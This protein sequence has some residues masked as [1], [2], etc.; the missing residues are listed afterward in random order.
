MSDSIPLPLDLAELDAEVAGGSRLRR[1]ILPS[2][3]RLIT[4]HVPGVA[5]AAIGCFVP[6]GSR[7]ESEGERGSSHFLEH[8]LFKG[9]AHRTAFEIA[10]SF[11]RVGGDFNASTSREETVYHAR[12][13]DHDLPLAIDVLADMMTSSVLDPADFDLE[14]GVILEEIAM[15]EDDPVDTLWERFYADYFGDHPL[16]LPIAG[17][18]ASIESV[19]RDDTNDFYRRTYRPER[20]VVAIAG[21]VDHDAARDQLDAGLRRG[22]W[23]LDRT[24][25]PV[26]RRRT[27]PAAF[28]RTVPLRAIERDLEQT[29][30]LIAGPGITSADPRRTA[31]GVLHHVLGGGMSSRLFQE[32][33][34]RRGLV[35]SVFSFAAFHADAGLSGVSLS[36]LP[37]KAAAA[38]DVVTTE[39]DRLA[40]D[41]ITDDELAD[42]RTAAIGAG[43][44]ALE[45][46]PARM[47]RLGRSELTLGEFT[48]LDALTSKMESVTASQVAE[49]ARDMTSSS[50]TAAT[51][52][53]LRDNARAQLE[54]MTR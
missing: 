38:I 29:N 54:R 50:L 26:A 39:V 11:E 24:S 13:R 35:Y 9:T 20:L 8:L 32:V 27:A 40:A 4:E 44:L 30:L 53:P 3:V 37:D 33:R 14:R 21:N 47:N 36:C 1:S 25:Q 42:A 31:L 52:G 5:S 17:T 2:G 12:V 41:G 48:D 43:A 7:D 15:D 51:I 23:D 16:G 22:G 28:T 49:L 34:E 18:P 46:M 45:S 10:R 19:S 6:L